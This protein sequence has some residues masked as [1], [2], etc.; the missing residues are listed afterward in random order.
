MALAKVSERPEK[1]IQDIP[2]IDPRQILF[3]SQ[4]FRGKLHIYD[5]DGTGEMVRLRKQLLSRP[6][7]FSRHEI[8]EICLEQPFRE[9]YVPLDAVE[10]VLELAKITVVPGARNQLFGK[11]GTWNH[12]RIGVPTIAPRLAWWEE[13]EPELAS[14]YELRNTL[15][16][17]IMNL[18]RDHGAT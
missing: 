14:A 7:F 17:T 3:N 4:G 8:R 6:H 5:L 2:G 16:A 11:D 12:L 13:K 9:C 10:E 18:L 15:V 1:L